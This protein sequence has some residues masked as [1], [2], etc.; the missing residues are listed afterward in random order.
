MRIDSNQIPAAR[1]S[2]LAY[3]LGRP[4]AVGDRLRT[5]ERA[6]AD[7]LRGEMQLMAPVSAFYSHSHAAGLAGLGECRQ[8]KPGQWDCSPTAEQI[9]AAGY[10]N[11][12]PTDGA[13][14][15]RN[16]AREANL[17]NI[18]N[19]NFAELS[20]V[21]IQVNPGETLDQA[22][23]RYSSMVTGRYFGQNAPS[24][25]PVPEPVVTPAV[26]P[27]APPPPP[28]PVVK[29]QTP[30]SQQQQL[31]QQQTQQTQ[32][33]IPSSAASS[34]PGSPSYVGAAPPKPEILV[35]NTQNPMA[36][37]TQTGAPTQTGGS[38]GSIIPNAPQR[39]VQQPGTGYAPAVPAHDN[40]KALLI[41]AVVVGVLFLMN[42]K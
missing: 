16:A 30:L 29:Q 33:T 15:A 3:A 40:Q 41:G 5:R 17:W 12:A 26:V 7:W 23:S 11:C 34:S 24:W 36:V 25:L 8:V 18:I 14:V 35:Y 39:T 10:E 1:T 9:A 20:Q 21:P 13:C 6:Y 2:F 38:S 37:G 28:P 31:V 27:T 19:S 42:K 22:G 4:V 32:Q